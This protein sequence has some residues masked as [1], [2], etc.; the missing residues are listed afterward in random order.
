MNALEVKNLTKRYRTGTVAVDDISFS[1]PKGE[2]FGFLG[3][4]GAGKTSTIHCITGIAQI[5][6][7][8]ISVMGRDIEKEYREARSHVGISPQDHN[9][10]IFATVTNI[11]D[12]NA[13]YFGL[14]SKE[15]EERIQKLLEQFE[16]E[17]HKDK[18]FEHL[19]GGLKRRVM[20]ARG[21]VHDPDILILDEPTAGIDVES[22]RDLWRY[23][24]NMAKEGK[25][26]I[27]TS[28]YLEEV[29]A[30]AQRVAVIHRGKIVKDGSLSDFTKGGKK[31][32]D[33]YLELIEN[34]D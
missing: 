6:S 8:S 27:L 5:T 17:E 32:E 12:Y 28:H 14:N 24:R 16:L 21:M 22:R 10:D 7:G 34:G 15:R 3:P 23:L 29:E 9:V 2:F 31:L 20:L 1:V 13:G 11:L 18:K 26:I 4:N 30:L 19:S 25:T 33:A